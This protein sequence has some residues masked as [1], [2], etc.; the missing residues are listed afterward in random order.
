MLEFWN[1]GV[2]SALFGFNI[3]PVFHYSMNAMAI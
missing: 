3:I 1:G 2:V